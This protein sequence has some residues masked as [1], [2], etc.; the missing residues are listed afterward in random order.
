MLLQR[1][2]VR[3]E[4]EAV[5]AFCACIAQRK[6]LYGDGSTSAAGT[7]LEMV[8]IL[9]RQ[10]RLDEAEV[11]AREVLALGRKETRSNSDT[12]QRS[13]YLLSGILADRGEFAEAKS[14]ASENLSL[15][16]VNGSSDLGAWRARRHLGGV[17]VSA[18]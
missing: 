18:K 11:A 12:L 5:R 3:I 4:D 17:L 16:T 10:R 14:L 9:H 8:G 1:P 13:L 6:K 7:L 2:I 15:R